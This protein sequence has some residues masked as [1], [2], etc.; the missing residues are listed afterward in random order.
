MRISIRA[1]VSCLSLL[2][3]PGAFAVSQKDAGLHDWSIPLIGQPATSAGARPRFHYPA[4]PAETATS[5]LVYTTTAR[6][7]LAAI[8]PR[9]GGIGAGL[10]GWQHEPRD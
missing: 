6:N 5:A 10:A 8:E 2:L 7:V 4:G 9:A 1:L 3:A